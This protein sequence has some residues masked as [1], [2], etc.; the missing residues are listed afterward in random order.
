MNSFQFSKNLLSTIK[1]LNNEQLINSWIY[2]GK[3]NIAYGSP[4]GGWDDVDGYLFEKKDKSY[5]YIIRSIPNQNGSCYI[6][7]ESINIRGQLYNMDLNNP[8][9]FI[10]HFVKT[11]L[12]ESYRMTAGKGK[13]KRN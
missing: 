11:N 8:R 5:S 7:I 2:K 4:N 10:E 3:T 13:K 9:T 1:S 6:V 12:L